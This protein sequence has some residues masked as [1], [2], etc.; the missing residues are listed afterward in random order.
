MTPRFRPDTRTPAAWHY[1][2]FTA[3]KCYLVRH[4][5]PRQTSTTSGRVL[6]PLTWCPTAARPARPV[7]S[8]FFR[9]SH[10]NLPSPFSSSSAAASTVAASQSPS[11]ST[12]TSYLSL[13][14]PFSPSSETCLTLPA[15][16]SIYFVFYFVFHLLLHLLL[17]FLHHPSHRLLQ[18]SQ[19]LQR[20]G[21]YFIFFF[22][23]TFESYFFFLFLPRRPLQS[24]HLFPRCNSFVLSVLSV[25]PPPASTASTLF[26][27]PV[28]ICILFLLCYLCHCPLHHLLHCLLHPTSALSFGPASRSLYLSPLSSVPPSTA[29]CLIPDVSITPTEPCH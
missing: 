9:A 29:S 23:T 2:R 21:L 18:P 5:R 16:Q 17:V 28:I 27:C 1:W 11:A 20:L 25:P 12:S 10:L 26:A 6:G 19:P 22:L 13:V 4:P 14:S 24:S 8:H 15:S 3:N 7:P